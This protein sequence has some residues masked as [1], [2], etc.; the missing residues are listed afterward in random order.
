VVCV[1]SPSLLVTGVSSF[2][3]GFF[4]AT[5]GATYDNTGVMAAPLSVI[6]ATFNGADVSKEINDGTF[7]PSAYADLTITASAEGYGSASTTVKVSNL[8]T[9]EWLSTNYSTLSADQAKSLF[10]GGWDVLTGTL[11]GRWANWNRNNTYE[12][13]GCNGGASADLMTIEDRLRMRQV[14]VLNVGYGLGRNV[15][16]SEMVNVLNTTPG[17]IVTTDIYSGLGNYAADTNDTYYY[18]AGSNTMSFSL[19][20]GTTLVQAALFSPMQTAQ[21]YTATGEDGSPIEFVVTDAEQMTCVITK[22]KPDKDGALVIPATILGYQ[23]TSI[24][25]DAVEDIATLTSVDIP[26][27]VTE[28]PGACF[29][30]STALRDVTVHWESPISIPDD[31]FRKSTIVEGTLHVPSEYADAY[32]DAAAWGDFFTHFEYQGLYFRITSFTEC[33]AELIG[34]EEGYQ[35]EI[36]IPEKAYFLETGYT[37]TSIASFAFANCTMLIKV[38]FPDSVTSMGDSVFSG[39]ASL[40]EVYMPAG[41]VS[42]GEGCFAGCTSLGFAEL[43]WKEGVES[44]GSDLFGYTTGTPGKYDDILRIR[45]P[46]TIKH[47]GDY[48]FAGCI[49][50]VEVFSDIT[51][52]FAF[53]DNVFPQ[54]A[55]EKAMLIVPDGTKSLYEST[56]GWMNFRNIVELSTVGITSSTFSGKENGSIFTI[57]GQRVEDSTRKGLYIANGKKTILR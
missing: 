39:C 34:R 53:S 16:S 37:V 48:A 3:D 42:M 32:S 5:L 6:T 43:V 21:T 7:V 35:G 55:Y 44:I 29:Q 28:L 24:T 46:K 4:L 15:E 50:L 10:G 2:K 19:R 18:L 20:G 13:V 47:I 26:A 17:Q 23:V 25:A 11:S 49:N 52:L 41:L 1:N 54:V 38:I 45:L 30:K 22:I 40:T 56:P 14:V 9:R 51:D 27:T 31:C 8:F 12:F 36:I 57:S 33:T